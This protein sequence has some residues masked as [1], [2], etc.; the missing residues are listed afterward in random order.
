MSMI[1]QAYRFALDPSVAQ[2]LTPSL[3]WTAYSLRKNWNWNDSRTNKRQGRR[4]GFPGFRGRRA[5]WSCR[6]TTGALGLVDM[7]RRH[8]KLPRIGVVRTHE[9][10]R[11]LARR[12]A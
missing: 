2:D 9:S 11:R 6:F 5:G 8:V 7:D 3:T 4:F 10:T 12:A 1:V